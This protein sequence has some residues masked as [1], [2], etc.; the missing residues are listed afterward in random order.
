MPKSWAKHQLTSCPNHG[1]NISWL[2]EKSYWSK[3][4]NFHIFQC[5]LRTLLLRLSLGLTKMCLP[6]GVL[7]QLKLESNQKTFSFLNIS[8]YLQSTANIFS[9]FGSFKAKATCFGLQHDG[10]S[11]HPVTVLTLRKETESVRKRVNQRVVYI[12]TTNSK[13]KF[14][15]QNFWHIYWCFIRIFW[16]P[17]VVKDSFF[18]RAASVTR[19][20]EISP[21]RKSLE[22]FGNI[23]KVYLI[24]D[25]VVNPLWDYLDAFGQNFNV[26]NGQI[27]KNNLAIWS[28]C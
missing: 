14:K 18:T 8:Q 13:T 24:F 20:G 4:L 10:L 27:L 21:I 28:H 7:K 26:V 22:I 9:Y 1:L 6:K 11:S 25:K 19:F 2:K 3:A 5:A 17:N 16:H 23:F 12:K 15:L